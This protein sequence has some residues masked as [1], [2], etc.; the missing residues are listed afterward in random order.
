[1]IVYNITFNVEDEIKDQWLKWIKND[2]IPAMTKSGLLKNP[3]LSELL[4]DEQQGTS[5]ALQFEANTIEDLNEFKKEQ[6]FSLLA[7]VRE[8]FGEKVV[9]FPTEMKVLYK[10][11]E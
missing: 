4:I 8:K 10:N 6:L 9:F 5:Y 3:R 7:P 1:M 2:F 11:K